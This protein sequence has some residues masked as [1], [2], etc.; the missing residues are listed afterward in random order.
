MPDAVA[1]PLGVKLLGPSA[2]AGL[3]RSLGQ[4]AYRQKQLTNWLYGRSVASYD[5]MTDLPA[6]LRAELA[7]HAPLTLP[8]LVARQESADGTRKYLWR[9][10]DGTAVESVGIPSGGRLTV[11]FSTQAGCRM[12]CSFCATGSGGFVRDLG[13]GEMVDQVALVASDFQARASNAVAMGQGE[14][15]DNYEAVLDGL[16]LMNAEAGLGIGARHL[17]VSTCGLVPGIARFATE[18]H[19]YTLA[20]SL[21]SAIQATRDSLMP[22]VRRYRLAALR[23]AIVAY[24]QATSRRVSLEYALIDGVNDTPAE[25]DALVTFCRGMMCHVNLIPLNPISDSGARRASGTRVSAFLS[26]LTSMGVEASIRS[27]RG[28]DIDAACGQLRQRA[29]V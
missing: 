5:E 19:Q 4:P 11:C 9:L 27:E 28:A 23:S 3:L 7:A 17:T 25:L 20:I 12:R 26:I 10:A 2:L 8:S 15:F 13:P 6:S 18:P 22:G 1:A 14:P 16:A 21:H 24:T 29:G